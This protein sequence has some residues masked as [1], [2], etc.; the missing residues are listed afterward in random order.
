MDNAHSNAIQHLRV[1]TLN[2]RHGANSGGQVVLG[3]LEKVLEEISA[4]IVCLQEVDVA[5]ARSGGEDQAQYL[6]THSKYISTFVPAQE[7][8]GGLYGLTVLTRQK[9]LVI[10]NLPLP[11]IFNG[12]ENRI[13]VAIRLTDELGI[14]NLHLSQHCEEAAVQINAVIHRLPEW[15]TII[16]GD[17]NLPLEQLLFDTNLWSSVFG[18]NREPLTWPADRPSEGLDHILVRKSIWIP[19]AAETVAAWPTDHLAVV[20]DLIRRNDVSASID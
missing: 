14:V 17:F 16:C 8:D 1:A 13:A 9:P 20:A 18:V 11:K 15:V 2:I 3:S 5:T 6:A 7:Y 19:T 4:D 12:S 10:R